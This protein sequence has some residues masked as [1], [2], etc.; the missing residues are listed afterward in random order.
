M[1]DLPL[2]EHALVTHLTWKVRLQEAIE[3]GHC[4]WPVADVRSDRACDL[5]R[6]LLDVPAADRASRHWRRI[7]R[8]HAAFHAAAAEVLALALAGHRREAEAALGPGSRYARASAALV[9]ALLAWKDV[10][11]PEPEKP[12]VFKK[13]RKPPEE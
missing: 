11:N 8:L 12:R 13:R 10:L 9:R 5:G 4:P 1:I 7:R 3:A 2:I 6:W